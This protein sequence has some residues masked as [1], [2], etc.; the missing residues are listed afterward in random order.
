MWKVCRSLPT[1][2]FYHFMALNMSLKCHGFIFPLTHQGG[3]M[4]KMP[5]VRLLEIIVNLFKWSGGWLLAFNVFDYSCGLNIDPKL[6]TL[7]FLT[8]QIY[9]PINVLPSLSRLMKVKYYLFDI[10]VLSR[11]RHF[12][13]FLIIG[14]LYR[15]LLV[16]EWPE[17]IMLMCPTRS[18][19]VLFITV[20]FSFTNIS[21]VF[22]FP[23][24]C[25]L[26]YWKG[27]SSNESSGWR[28]STFIRGPGL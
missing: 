17:G 21:F 6:N 19:I 13:C 7:I 23:A 26:C 28:R 3:L 4:W 25:K 12:F 24:L 22:V 16:R 27:C 15:V 5:P 18:D 14:H 2:F 1:S 10:K 11:D 20:I 9:P 8:E